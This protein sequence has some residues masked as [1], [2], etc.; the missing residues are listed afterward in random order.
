MGLEERLEDSWRG[1][2][3]E[4]GGKPNSHWLRKRVEEVRQIVADSKARL[5]YSELH[6]AAGERVLKEY[7]D[8]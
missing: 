1:L 5:I 8:G 7:E 6:L 4:S 2:V 3:I